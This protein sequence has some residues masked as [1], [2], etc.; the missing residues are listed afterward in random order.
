MFIRERSNGLYGP[1]SYVLANTITVVPFLSIGVVLFTVIVYWAIGLTGGVRV[2][3]R[4]LLYL[5]LGITAAEFQSLLIAT[6]VPIFVAALALAAFANGL[7]MVVQGYFIKAT[8]LPD[9]WYYSVSLCSGS[10]SAH[11]C[12]SRA[13]RLALAASADKATAYSFTTWTIKLTPST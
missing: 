3:F 2:F 8:Q 6:I 5:G 9:F 12:R 10:S 7:W 4:F 1:G 13:S 11:R